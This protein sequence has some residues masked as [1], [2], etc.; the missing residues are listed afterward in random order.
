MG[1][2]QREIVELVIG[3]PGTSVHLTIQ[4]KYG[5]PHVMTAPFQARTLPQS[6]PLSKRYLNHATVSVTWL[7]VA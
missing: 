5:Y 6:F 7:D 4:S 1:M 3:P 2:D